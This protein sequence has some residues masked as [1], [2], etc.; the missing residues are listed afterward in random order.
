MKK[1]LLVPL[2]FMAACFF[3][4]AQP[5]EESENLIYTYGDEN[6]PDDYETAAS[7]PAAPPETGPARPFLVYHEGLSASWLTRIIKQ[8]SRSNFV[9]QDFLPGLYFGM[10]LA[11]VKYVTPMIR[12]TA[13][14]P[15]LSTFNKIPQPP[16]SPLHFGVD[17]FGGPAF[18]ITGLKYVRF[19]LT[20]GLHLLFL[21]SDRWNYF[22]LGI[23]G[24]VGIEAPLTRGWTILANG[25]ASL[26]NGSLGGNRL[27]EPFDIVYQYQVDI[28]VRYSKK[29]SN[30]FSYICPKP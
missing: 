10:G 24:L 16:K 26:D 20:P 7:D 29:L 6:G 8:T 13:Y 11:N 25:I 1:E 2:L 4:A 22:N 30:S 19:N 12:L 28:G 9:Y 15:L 17:F 27:M 14:Y 21:N 23:A 18:Q 5:A 3:A